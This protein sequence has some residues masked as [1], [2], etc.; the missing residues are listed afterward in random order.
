MI[1]EE[2]TDDNVMRNI[3]IQTGNIAAFLK[4]CFGEIT[5]QEWIE[6]IKVGIKSQD[7]QQKELQAL[8]QQQEKEFVK[9]LI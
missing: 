9:N 4:Y 1:G 2:I 8:V 7:T 5:K 3:S 6:I